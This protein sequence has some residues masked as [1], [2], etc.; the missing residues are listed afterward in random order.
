M[1]IPIRTANLSQAVESSK[2]LELVGEEEMLGRV[3]S[4]QPTIRSRAAEAAQYGRMLWGPPQTA[5]IF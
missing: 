3:R 5:Y 2:D 1:S 4:F